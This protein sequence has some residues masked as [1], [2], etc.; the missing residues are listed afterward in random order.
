MAEQDQDKS[1]KAT[2]FKLEEARRRG[3][4][5]KSLDVNSF[6]S[7][8]GA[9]ALLSLWGVNF[10]REGAMLERAIFEQASSLRFDI[11]DL[12]TWFSSIG[13]TVVKMLAPFFVVVIVIAVLSNVLQT[14]PIFSFFPL[15]PDV[16]R[17]SPIQG[18]KRIFSMRILFDA[19]K[20]FV[21]LVLVVAVAYAVIVDIFPSII[22]MLQ[23]D[24]KAYPGLLLDAVVLLVFKLVLVLLLVAVLD[25]LY[26]R[27][28]FSKKM[29]MSRRETK[30]EVK[31]REGDPLIRAKIKELQREMAKRAKSARRVPEADV[32]ITNP[33]HFAVALKYERGTAR[34]PQVIAKGVGDAALSMRAIAGKHG[35][36]ILERPSL[37]RQLYRDVDIDQ[38]I[39]EDAYGPVAH[40]YAELYASPSRASNVV[41]VELQS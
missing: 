3:Q 15:K 23:T 28:E 26:T 27:R 40:I 2:P 39:P 8:A 32:L 19:L 9:L 22:A 35:V 20:T 31:R 16:K 13:F 37:A 33:T 14:G 17:L 11:P 6:L 1:E 12:I 4:V 30:D 18:F 29:R 41:R 5:A 34:A 21:K 10:I 25:L 7:I 38:S 24:P 36:P